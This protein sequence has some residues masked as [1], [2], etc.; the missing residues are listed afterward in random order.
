[1]TAVLGF[2]GA[3]GVSASSVP[4][5]YHN[6]LGSG[7]GYAEL[8]V[9]WG[10]GLALDNLAQAVLFNGTSTVEDILRT[11]LAEDSRFYALSDP[12]GQFV[13]FGF[14]TNGDYSA[15]VSLDGSVLT[16]NGGVAVASGDYST[17]AGSSVY[18]HWAVNNGEKSW[19]VFINGVRAAMSSQVSSGD[20]LSLEYSSVSA[21]EPVEKAYTF[22]LRPD[23]EQGIWTVD[24]LILNTAVDKVGSSVY[25]LVPMIANICGDSANL[26]GAKISAEVRG[27]DNETLSN[28]YSAYIPDAAKGAMMLRVTAVKPNECC[29]VPYLNIRKNW[30][31]GAVSVKRVYSDSP[32]RV[33]TILA[34][35]VKGISLKEYAQGET[36]EVDNMGCVLITP[37]YEPADADFA[38][39]EVCFADE[40]VATLYSSIKGIVAHKAGETVMTLKVPGTDVSS[41]YI[42]KVKG[43]DP[44]NIP[45]D[46][47]ADGLFWLNE[48]WFTHTSGSINYIDE[49]GDM[50]YRV[51]GNQ[52]DNAAFGATSQY[53]MIYADKL[54]VMSK[55]AWDSG[56]TRPNRTGGRVVVADAKTM[57]RIAAFDEIGGDGRACV[58]VN[59]GKVYLSHTKGVRVMHLDGDEISLEPVDIAGISVSGASGQMGD[60]VKAGKYVFAVNVAKKL[61][62]ID[63]ESDELVK[64]IDING[65]QTVAQSL[66]GRVWIGCSKTLQSIDPETLELGE[67]LT[68]GAGSIGCSS[69]SWRSGNLRASVKSNTLFWSTSSYNGSN[70]DLVRWDIDETEDPSSLTAL[71]THTSN[72]EGYSTGYGTPNYD[73]RSDTWMYASMPGFGANSIKNRLHFIDAT[74]G[75]VLH[76]K[77]LS[78]YFWFPAMAIV[79]DKYLP[80]ILLEDLVLPE[81]VTG[82]EVYTYDLADYLDDLDNHNGNIS[83]WLEGVSPLAG[84]EDGSKTAEVSLDGKELRIHPLNNGYHTFTLMAESNGRTVSKNINVKIGD[85]TTGIESV[86]IRGTVFSDGSMI[87]FRNLGGQKIE[88]FDMNGRAIDSFT[89]QDEASVVYPQ[90]APGFYMLRASN[91]LTFKFRI[92]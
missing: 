85:K 71:Y 47:F 18:D 9:H 3:F 51:Y 16:L 52:N 11:A 80:E 53:G 75:E 76:N 86:D 88:V 17:S 26:Y 46:D 57:K 5:V 83:V 36:I 12:D 82:D 28:D 24:E 23:S 73:P 43:V 31:D 55:Q 44:S 15:S 14:D 33:S 40:S 78:T 92:N 59:P 38:I 72:P 42:V 66:D 61:E 6:E 64:S 41:D 67:L 79:P 56:D 81:I 32:L 27:T 35:P 39:F 48:E 69:S 49:N 89:V 62:I 22:Y 68:I 4:E 91:G 63:C 87:A 90:Y 7:E 13:A 20:R 84:T 10:D 19:N 70:G 34:N 29:V 25:R 74:S 2:S 60:M 58:G 1:M 8:L 50:Y 54:F 21:E 45:G 30:G 77:E 37:Q 65:I